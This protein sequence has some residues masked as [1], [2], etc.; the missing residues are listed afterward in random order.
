[1]STGISGKHGRWIIIAGTLLIYPIFL[2]GIS[3]NPPGF[4][5][6]ESCIAYN[7]YLIATTGTAENGDSF[8]LFIQCYS[9]NSIGYAH[10]TDVYLLAAMFLFVSPSILSARILAATVV[11]IAMILLGLLATKISERRLIGVIV[12]LTAM[13]TPWFFE[14]SRL[15]LDNFVFVFAV[16]LFLLFLHNAY[17]SAKWS[18]SHSVLIAVSLALITYSYTSGRL[19]APAFA[20][21][22]LLFAVNRALIGGILKTWAIYFFT[23]IP[24]IVLNFTNEAV[25]SKRFKEVTYILPDRTW[26][27]IAWTFVTSYFSDL[28][29]RFLLTAGDPLQRHH[30][31]GEGEIYV[32]TFVL[33]VVGIILIVF[34]F[35]RD[36]WWLFVIFGLFVSIVP[37]AITV[38][39]HHTLRLLAFPVFFM[40]FTIPAMSW[41]LGDVDDKSAEEKH[42]IAFWRWPK[43]KLLGTFVFVVLMALTVGQAVS[44]HKEFRRIGPERRVAYDAD[45]PIILADALAQPAR[46]IYLKD[47]VAGPAYIDAYWYATMQGIDLANFYHLA[48]EEPIPA[49]VLVLSSD[50]TCTNCEVI[51][52]K[53]VYLLYKTS[54]ANSEGDLSNAKIVGS[55]GNKP[56]EFSRPRGVAVDSSGNFYVADTGN[57][58]VQKF[59]S[60]G[61]FLLSFGV[62]GKGVGELNSPNGIAVD[63]DG[64]IYVV[65]ASNNKLLRFGSDGEFQ[66]EWSKPEVEFYG[67]RD[68]ATA[69]DGKLYIVDQGRSRIVKFD[70]A[71]EEF[72]SFGSPGKGEGQFGEPMGIA[73]GTGLVF[74]TES[75]NKRIQVFDL[76]GNFVRQW[77]VEVWEQG[78]DSYPDC[79]FDTQANRLYV[80]SG[81]TKDMIVFDTNG[82]MMDDDHL[83]G[84]I[85]LNKPSG[86]C[87]STANNTKTLIVLDITDSKAA[88][89]PVGPDKQKK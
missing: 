29:P 74:V 40:L 2:S 76:D 30:I 55:I 68:M 79:E 37:G 75:G 87:L 41:L 31:T 77:P 58:R 52:Q 19:L 27:T 70:P 89:I 25:I 9:G 61:A 62:F 36:R 24:L 78:I 88:M 5:V 6:D 11:F 73:I 22:M 16:V 49:D 69:P 51:S 39:R 54:P 4:Y 83:D 45:Y 60:D 86:L 34:K 21:G 18:S 59:D 72:T 50:V 13:A 28:S 43:A 53:S 84:N 63:D 1:M 20:L 12:S 48:E 81:V 71:T 17:K 23:L 32:A 15:V 82:N 42:S 35:R 33:A 14:I 66:K 26:S 10:P 44:F 47:G 65:D 38:H 56:G 67:P 8:P 57:H 64:N 7:G 46:P 80:T 3:T 85:K